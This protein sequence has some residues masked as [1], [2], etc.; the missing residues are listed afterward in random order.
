MAVDGEEGL[1]VSLEMESSSLRLCDEPVDEHPPHRT[2]GELLATD[3]GG[4]I[5]C[6]NAVSDAKH[7]SRRRY[8][9]GQFDEAILNRI[10]DTL[11]RF[12]AYRQLT[13][14]TPRVG[15][16]MLLRLR[17]VE[18]AGDG[19]ADQPYTYSVVVGPNEPLSNLGT[20]WESVR[21]G[22][23]AANVATVEGFLMPQHGGDAYRWSQTAQQVCLI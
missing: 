10:R 16:P 2:M 18:P 17:Y 4:T 22:C 11:L 14:A 19:R 3:A 21:L 5:R 6:R 13:F 23:K 20:A 8:I 1:F 9:E 12:T 15:R 7:M